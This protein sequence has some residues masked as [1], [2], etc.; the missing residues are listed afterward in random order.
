MRARHLGLAFVAVVAVAL[1][2]CKVRYRHEVEPPGTAA[3]HITGSGGFIRYDGYE[4]VAGDLE[5]PVVTYKKR[6]SP[7]V[8]RMVGVLHLGD[9]AYYKKI[10]EILDA[11]DLVLYEGI[12]RVGEDEPDPASKGLYGLLADF[13][14]L[15]GQL[16]AIDYDRP[17]FVQCDLASE[18]GADELISPGDPATKETLATLL[19]RAREIVRLKE[20][21]AG[22][23]PL[24]GQ[25]D[26]IKHYWALGMSG[27]EELG[28]TELA[29]SVKKMRESLESY[30]EDENVDTLK[31]TCEQL[32]AFEE[33]LR[34]LDE[35]I[36]VKRNEFVI[37]R[38]EA[39]IARVEKEETP[40]K[41]FTIAI[42]YGA[43]HL[44][45]FHE[46]LEELG[47]QRA[48]TRWLKAWAMN[49]RQD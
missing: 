31:E 27:S 45:D 12:H 37:E 1:S 16:D 35:F 25:E 15:T 44:P 6:G 28:F 34:K 13:V 23:F 7:I 17:H 24:T 5:I 40:G 10:Q 11:S 32:R 39:E 49:S 22:V 42:F 38:L 29:D 46:R 2:A 43:G 41:E 21:V 30:A 47:Y 33:Q 9:R 3:K 20:S 8:I 26:Y 18:E 4:D 48:K 14:G 36:I 19:E